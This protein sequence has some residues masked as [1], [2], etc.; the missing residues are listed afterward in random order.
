MTQNKVEAGEMGAMPGMVDQMMGRMPAMMDRMFEGITP[1]GRR[2]FMESMMERCIT[3]MFSSMTDQDRR[4]TAAGM[5]DRMAAQLRG[6]TDK[7]RSEGE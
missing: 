4:E 7:D 3:T 1:E 6:Y 2:T 5:L